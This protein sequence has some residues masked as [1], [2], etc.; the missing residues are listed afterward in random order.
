MLTEITRCVIVRLTRCVIQF[1][2]S[3]PSWNETKWLTGRSGVRH[4]AIF[5]SLGTN[6]G[7]R[8]ANLQRAVAA[9]PPAVRVQAVS[10][11]YKTQPWGYRDQPYFL[12]MCLAAESDL[13]PVALLQQLQS[14]EREL[15]R[16]PGPRWGPRL[17]DIDILF[18]GQ[19]QVHTPY[20]TIP[21]PELAQ[22]AF[23]LIPLAALAPDLVHPQTGQ[24][25]AQMAQQVDATGVI[26]EPTPFVVTALA[27]AWTAGKPLC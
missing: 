10:P 8:L 12:N 15:G 21:H 14:L 4:E 17:I 3:F 22:R 27:V 16:R 1:A 2:L 6:L 5:L 23:V 7:D 9:L 19:R 18:Y 25:V 13:T 11:I 26:L 20:L 24:S